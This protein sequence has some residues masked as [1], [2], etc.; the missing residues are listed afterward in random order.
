MATVPTAEIQSNHDTEYLFDNSGERAEAR[1]RDLSAL[2]DARTIHYLK[3]GGLVWR[4][5]EE[6]DRSPPGSVHEWGSREV[7]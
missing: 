2:Y 3:K 5:A 4:S 7:C 1:F 6:A